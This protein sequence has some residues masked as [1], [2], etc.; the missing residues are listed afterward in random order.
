MDIL[1]TLEE[2]HRAKGKVEVN[3][4]YAADDEDML[5]T[6]QEILEDTELAY[7]LIPYQ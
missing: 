5:E 2:Y 6:G 3:W 7:N 1:D 4:Y